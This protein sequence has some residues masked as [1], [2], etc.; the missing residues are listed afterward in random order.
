[1]SEAASVDTSAERRRH[2]CRHAG[3]PDA[4]CRH[5]DI[6]SSMSIE[7]STWAFCPWSTSSPA[8][9]GSG[10]RCFSRDGS[11]RFLCGP[12]SRCATQPG[13]RSGSPASVNNSINHALYPVALPQKF[14]SAGRPAGQN[15][16][17]QCARIFPHQHGADN[18]WKLK[19]GQSLV[20]V[21]HQPLARNHAWGTRR[22]QIRQVRSAVA[23]DIAARHRRRR[24]FRCNQFRF[25]AWR[26]LKTTS[27]ATGRTGARAGSG[28][29][30]LVT[31]ENASR[32]FALSIDLSARRFPELRLEGFYIRPL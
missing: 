14:D 10:R 27:I 6:R 12:H 1:M 26:T 3:R 32:P 16:F 25:I 17:R 9:R 23:T 7:C 29:I 22:L 4:T 8:T 31:P 15:R 21:L 30:T 5:I 28:R 11:A 24:R 20:A 18:V 19:N 13:S 2:C